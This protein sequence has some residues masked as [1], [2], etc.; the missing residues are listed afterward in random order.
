MFNLTHSLWQ[1]VVLTVVALTVAPVVALGEQVQRMAVIGGTEVVVAGKAAKVP[2]YCVDLKAQGT[3]H[4][5]AL[6]AYQGDVTVWYAKGDKWVKYG[7]L[8]KAIKDQVLTVSGI[9]ITDP[10]TGEVMGRFDYLRA[11]PG[12]K[13]D[14]ATTYL[15]EVRRRGLVRGGRQGRQGRRRGH[16][17]A[18]QIGHVLQAHPGPGAAPCRKPTGCWSSRARRPRRRPT[19]S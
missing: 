11:S 9:D 4:G 15:R 18:G 7:S 6:E 12:A 3:A 16:Q 8:E 10:I 19:A 1:R 17:G 13:W 5:N 2:A 14:G